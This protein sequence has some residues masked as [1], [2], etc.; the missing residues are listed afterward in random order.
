MSKVI[1]EFDSI[2][3]SDEIQDAINGWKWKNAMWD[4]DQKLRDTTKYSKSVIQGQDSASSEECNI[5]DR[6][7]ELIREILQDN[8]LY[9]D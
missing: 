3:E 1:L 5:A 9:F 4:L 2:E 7:R 8:K 6:Y